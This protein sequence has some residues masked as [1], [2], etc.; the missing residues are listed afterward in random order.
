MRFQESL[1][2]VTVA[3]PGDG[4]YIRANIELIAL[5]NRDCDYRVY[6]LDNSSGL[7]GAPIDIKSELVTILE[8]VPQDTSYS[9]HCRGSYHHAAALNRF[10]R[11]DHVSTRYLLILDPDF[12]ILQESWVAAVL[13]YMDEKGLSFF[14]AP[15]HPKW[16]TKYRYFPCAHCMF[17][18]RDRIDVKTLD[19]TPDLVER[20]L[21]KEQKI[22][23]MQQKGLK[24]TADNESLTKS[25]CEKVVT[26]CRK[27]RYWLKVVAHSTSMSLKALMETYIEN[28][29]PLPL[30]LKATV[31]CGRFIRGVARFPRRLHGMAR[32]LGAMIVNRRLIRSSDDTGYLVHRAFAA[33]NGHKHDCLTP[34][35]NYR[36]D[37]LSPPHLRKRCSRW[38]EELFPDSLS[39]TPRRGTFITEADCKDMGALS[40]VDSEWEKFLW[41]GRPF[42]FHMRRYNKVRREPQKE[43]RCLRN[44]GVQTLERLHPGSSRKSGKSSFFHVE[45][46]V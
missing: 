22:K 37:F 39:F 33:N 2:I 4:E 27:T 23:K 15:W 21:A 5:L 11:E 38:I 8:G 16:F 19:F 10:L 44:V 30:T 28:G 26:E 34:V 14:G 18:D 9:P 32:G 46:L 42:G 25:S 43:L 40:E 1:S 45:Q 7:N 41:N 29:V 17:I 12:Y 20:S 35:I 6:V 3:G 13:S 36:T 31:R 24:A